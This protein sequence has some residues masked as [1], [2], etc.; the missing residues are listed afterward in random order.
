MASLNEVTQP[1]KPQSMLQLEVAQ[2][3]N[4]DAG[5][6]AMTQQEDKRH[7]EQALAP[8]VEQ[9]IQEGLLNKC[10]C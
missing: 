7:K 10:D 1:H 9:G 6:F 8:S 5:D 2:P 4:D 3:S